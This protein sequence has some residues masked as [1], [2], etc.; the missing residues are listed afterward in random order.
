MNN[1]GKEMVIDDHFNIVEKNDY[2]ILILDEETGIYTFLSMI[3]KKENKYKTNIKCKN[4]TKL[5]NGNYIIELRNKKYNYNPKEDYMLGD[6]HDVIYEFEIHKNNYVLCNV[7]YVSCNK[8]YASIE[9]ITDYDGNYLG[10][11]YNKF[12]NEYYNANEEHIYGLVK[13]YKTKLKSI[14]RK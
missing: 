6:F 13:K 11:C 4:A 9:S 14:G 3:D 8:K 1:N 5:R 10:N 2:Y 7:D 12:S